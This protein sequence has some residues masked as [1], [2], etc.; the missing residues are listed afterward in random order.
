[1]VLISVVIPLYNKGSHIKSTLESIL[2][3]SYQNFEII[4][5]NDGST[6]K[7]ESEVLKLDDTRIKY[8]KTENQ[9]V[10]QARNFGMEKATGSLIA[11]LDADDYWFP[12]HLE[13]LHFLYQKYPEAGFFATNYEFYYSEKRIEYPQFLDITPDFE[14]GIV[15]DFFKS[16]Y[17]Y[18]LTWTSAVAIPKTVID[19]VGGFDP[20]ITLG[21][22]EDVDYWIRVALKHK[23]AFHNRISARYKMDGENRIS[24][25]NTLKRKFAKLDSFKNEE[26]NN[27][28][29][30]KYL[31]LYRAEF[32]LK[33]KLA[34]DKKQFLFYK[35]ALTPANISLK[36]R[37]LL[38][39]PA[40]V[41]RLLYKF[42]KSLENKGFMVNAY[43]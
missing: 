35:N 29:L 22:G 1:M 3:Q 28:W 26:A 25:S 17:L 40:S 38:E 5:V 32:A 24:H 37:I 12:N 42:K 18:R 14:H 21:A 10:S 11:F 31:D 8:F 34:G 39:M 7:S 43:H 20:N 23:V 36:T 13:D 33:F 6:D 4:V 15:K 27:Y 2:A 16:S 19:Q 41:L 9:G 30:R